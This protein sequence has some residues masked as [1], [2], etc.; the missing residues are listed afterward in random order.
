MIGK[1]EARLYNKRREFYNKPVTDGIKEEGSDENES[2]LG[3]SIKI[4]EK[5]SVISNNMSI[6]LTVHSHFF[7]H[8]FERYEIQHLKSELLMTMIFKGLTLAL[9]V[10]LIF[11]RY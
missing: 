1:E 9:F 6:A 8:K 10:L 5:Q 11:L 3:N 2:S 4:M 7:D